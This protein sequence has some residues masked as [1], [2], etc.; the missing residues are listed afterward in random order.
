MQPYFPPETFSEHEARLTRV[1]ESN[2]LLHCAARAAARGH[3]R[4]LVGHALVNAGVRL[5][6]RKGPRVH[7]S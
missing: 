4:L 2:R 3:L 6:P 5:L 1:A 7:P